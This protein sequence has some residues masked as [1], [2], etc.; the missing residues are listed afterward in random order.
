MIFS[1]KF[2]FEIKWRI[3]FLSILVG[4]SCSSSVCASALPPEILFKNEDVVDAQLSP[5]GQF[6]ALST[7]VNGRKC[8]AVMSMSSLKI[9]EI[10]E[11]SDAEIG[12][13]SWIT[14][15]RLVFSLNYLFDEKNWS[16]YISDGLFSVNRDG[17][18]L[19]ELTPTRK[20]QIESGAKVVKYSYQIAHFDDSPNEILVAEVNSS[21]PGVVPFRLN[22]ITGK[23]H[24]IELSIS[25]T[26]RQIWADRAQKIRLVKT[27]SG[28]LGLDYLWYRKTD[29]SS[30]EKIADLDVLNPE[31]Y[32]LAFDQDNK[33]FYVASRN[34]S[35]KEAIYEY[36]FE[37]KSIGNIVYRNNNADV[38]GGLIFSRDG[39]KLFGVR[40][41]GDVPGVI[42]FDHDRKEVQSNI[43]YSLPSQINEITGDQESEGLLIKSYSDVL[44]SVYYY[45]SKKNK[46]MFKLF[47]S[48]PWIK[49]DD[50]SHQLIFHYKARDGLDIPA[51][52]TLPKDRVASSLPLIVLVHGGPWMRDYWGFNPELQ[53]L[54]S[55]GYAVLQPQFR[56]STGFG[57]ALFEKGW[58]QWG[59]SMQNDLADGVQDLI[60]QGVVDPH[61]IC[62][63]GSS[64][65]GYAAL[66]GLAKDSSIYRCGIDMFGITDIELSL[67]I[68]DWNSSDSR[69]FKDYQFKE[70]IG[71]LETDKEKFDA[72]SPLKLASEIRAPVMMVYGKKDSR[73]PALEGEL[74]RKA[75]EKKGN[76]VDWTLLQNEGHGFLNNL[77]NK[78]EFYSRLD[79]FL[80][81]FNPAY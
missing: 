71:N 40:F 52:L 1:N 8:L 80:N 59:S 57:K 4:I 68:S 48:M 30:W 61:K 47:S 66:M 39:H 76:L 56:S 11:Y 63:M 43:D 28:V 32:P 23:A 20:K 53:F 54:A 19:K 72:I 25:G 75:L 17:S 16:G 79:I 55:R 13:F 69:V 81:K 18:S 22:I 74:L 5:N 2:F 37:N 9:R 67:N 12:S 31:F 64:Y 34:G 14:N 38:I 65:G 70:L 29:E 33:T 35:D 46:K 10:A 77:N 45:Y 73:V 7:S 78:F 49:S 15:E 51:Y 60:R 42:W 3:I 6:V 26:I 21:Q 62:I 41:Q 24:E 58:K 27:S 44:P 50:L 36:N